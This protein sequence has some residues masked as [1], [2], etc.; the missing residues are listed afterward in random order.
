MIV[1]GDVPFGKLPPLQ[2]Q[3]PDLVS[4]A[5]KGVKQLSLESIT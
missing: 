4:A 2:A 3:G 1:Q 5:P